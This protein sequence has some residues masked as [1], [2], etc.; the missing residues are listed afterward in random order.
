MV[1]ITISQISE[2]TPKDLYK[3]F[4]DAADFIRLEEEA[5][6]DE[7]KYKHV[8]SIEYT[9]RQLLQ[10]P[11]FFFIAGQLPVK[12]ITS[13]FYKN[14]VRGPLLVAAPI[15]QY[16][17]AVGILPRQFS[18]NNSHPIFPRNQVVVNCD[19]V[20]LNKLKFRQI[21]VDRYFIAEQFIPETV[22]I[23]EPKL[24]ECSA[25]EK[26]LIKHLEL[27]ISCNCLN[28]II[29]HFPEVYFNLY[30]K[31]DIDTTQLDITKAKLQEYRLVNIERIKT[32][33]VSWLYRR[34]TGMEYISEGYNL[35]IV[36]KNKGKFIPFFE[37]KVCEHMIRANSEITD[38]LEL[39]KE[40]TA[41]NEFYLCSHGN[42]IYCVHRVEVE[43][44]KRGGVS[45]SDMDTFIASYKELATDKFFVCKICGEELKPIKENLSLD[46]VYVGAL[47]D[48]DEQERKQVYH[49]CRF[50]V[51]NLE[52]KEMVSDEWKKKFTGNVSEIIYP[53]VAVY[54][55]KFKKY[56]NITHEHRVAQSKIISFIYVYA[57]LVRVISDNSKMVKFR[58]QKSREIFPAAKKYLLSSISGYIKEIQEFSSINVES[59]LQKAIDD[60]NKPAKIKREEKVPV[61]SIYDRINF[62]TN[63]K[64]LEAIKNFYAEPLFLISTA[65]ISRNDKHEFEIVVDQ[66]AEYKA[67]IKILLEFKS[68]EKLEQSY[69]PQYIFPGIY[70]IDH[71]YD[72]NLISL[73]IGIKGK[74]HKHFWGECIVA[75][76][77]EKSK[78]KNK[79]KNKLKPLAN[80][81]YNE[82]A[83]D[84][85]CSIC[86]VA[87]SEAVQ[88]D[89]IK[90]IDE[91]FIYKSK[92]EF[93]KN[94]CP[95]KIHHEFKRD[96]CEFCGYPSAKFFE[97]YDLPENKINLPEKKPYKIETE[98]QF[99]AE[100]IEAKYHSFGLKKEEYKYFWENIGCYEDIEYIQLLRQSS[101][102]REIGR[103]NLTDLFIDMKIFL[104]KNI[105]FEYFNMPD[106]G[107]LKN[108]LIKIVD[109]IIPIPFSKMPYAALRSL[110]I[111]FFNKFPEKIAVAYGQ[112]LLTIHKNGAKSDAKKNAT[113][114]IAARENE[115]EEHVD[116]EGD[117]SAGKNDFNYDGF[118]YNG[119]NVK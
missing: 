108:D 68:K 88:K 119:E 21:N 76:I 58:G 11:R 7:I 63:T 49:D 1:K 98:Q 100:K 42:K 90:K 84:F 115:F 8:N 53:K 18:I 60:L 47:F 106:P 55:E 92:A 93:F 59:V 78:E 116:L 109:E 74:I 45:K 104:Q 77:G 19:L 66:T 71:D 24:R 103:I 110:F 36:K 14:S 91:D 26:Q 22:K 25:I 6:L 65:K 52:F 43:K 99:T 17:E 44:L 29:S 69:L 82:I 94:F 15:Q 23:I 83:T 64:I 114:L 75:N 89:T 28:L 72:M 67:N 38:I 102:S 97:D 101:P 81:E 37:N 54:F 61:K 30:L 112:K 34:I 13:A 87:K 2:E 46:D 16:I 40:L 20:E 51:S 80:L 95:E 39:I 3:D 5:V 118:D 56:K 96:V 9:L 41:G 85:I 79:L 73:I 57:Y 62:S 107:K 10:S 12:L 31:R 48:Y 86:G 32:V 105:N 35:K 70:K 113:S 33:I 117:L 50:A 111:K 4:E 27:D